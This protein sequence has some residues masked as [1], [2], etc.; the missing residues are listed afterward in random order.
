MPGEADPIRTPPRVEL[1]TIRRESLS[2]VL[3]EIAT[4]GA[5]SRATLAHRLGFNP[6][7]ISSLASELIASGLVEETEEDENPGKVGRPARLL[8][9]RGRAFG[10]IGLEINVDYYAACLLDLDGAVRHQRRVEISGRPATARQAM[11]AVARLGEEALERAR[12]REIGVH[13]VTLALPGLVEARLG[14]L[15]LAPN[16]G[17]RDIEPARLLGERL[18]G[19]SVAIDN[20]ANLGALAEL[21][22]GGVGTHE[23]AICISG[24]VGIGAGVLIDGSLLRGRHGFGGEF[25]HVVVDPAGARCACGG[26]GC[27]ET[28]AGKHAILDSGGAGSG[29]ELLA[30][31]RGGDRRALAAVAAAG[32]ALGTALVSAIQLLDPGVVIV[33]GF[34]GPLLPWLTTS[35]AEELNARTTTTGA[36]PCPV[37]ASSLGEWSAVRGAATQGLTAMLA[38]PRIVCHYADRNP[39][40]A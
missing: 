34:L 13:G 33:G 38:D 25:G 3:A 16:L 22:E 15:V 26:R 11:T 12:A 24:S 37:I 8:R 40:A 5:R 2:A 27:L 30:L 6:S 31:L 7:T 21:W 28:V 9:L 29:A 1:G 4:G 35:F 23:D 32:A 20:E 14:R 36:P 17:W 18:L 19:V 39:V 10:A